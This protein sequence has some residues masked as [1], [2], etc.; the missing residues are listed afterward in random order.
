MKQFQVQFH[1]ND[2]ISS[3]ILP[4]WNYLNL[5]CKRQKYQIVICS[6]PSSLYVISVHRKL[7]DEQI[8]LKKC[9]K[10]RNF[11]PILSLHKTKREKELFRATSW[12]SQEVFLFPSTK[13]IYTFEYII[14][15]KAR[16]SDWSYSRY[17]TVTILQRNCFSFC[18]FE[19]PKQE[20]IK[21]KTTKSEVKKTVNSSWGAP[22]A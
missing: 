7:I 18:C 3:L 14:Y 9:N 5:N 20:T 11:Y 13:S 21:K 15:F 2:Q 22:I 1:I 19:P 6:N 16:P 17:T 8:I 4:L 12:L 10:I